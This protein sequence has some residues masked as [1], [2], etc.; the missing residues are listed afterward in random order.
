MMNDA[1]RNDYNIASSQSAQDNFNRV[2]NQLE[3]LL[4]RRNG[5]VR[6][7]L[8]RYEADGVS[9]KYQ[10][11][12]HN[13]DNAGREVRTISHTIR[14]AMSGNDAVAQ[15]ALSKASAAVHI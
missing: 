3:A 13:W 10:A 5:D 1:N 12:E 4:D 15:S 7:A 9:D 6:S 11:L 2:A 8:A 14:Q